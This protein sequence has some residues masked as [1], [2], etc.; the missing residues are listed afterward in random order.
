MVEGQATLDW[1][2]RRDIHD[3]EMTVKNE[4]ST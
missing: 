4:K 3:A 1:I 2:R